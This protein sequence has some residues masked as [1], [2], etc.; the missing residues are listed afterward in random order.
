MGEGKSRLAQGEGVD[1]ER[2]PCN[3]GTLV[4]SK[5]VAKRRGLRNEYISVYLSEKLKTE[6]R[7]T[8][9]PENPVRLPYIPAERRRERERK[10]R[11]EGREESISPRSRPLS[12]EKLPENKR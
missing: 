3:W 9:P 1:G 7:E 8:A 5:P 2:E 11:E 6:S 10:K 4:G 12:S